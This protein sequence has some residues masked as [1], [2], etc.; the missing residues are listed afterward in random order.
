ML[1]ELSIRDIALI[2]ELRLRFGP[3]LTVLS[4][5]TGAG[6]SLVVGGLRLL[7][8]ERS[9]GEVVRTG[10][11]L[12]VVEG[13]FEIPAGGWIA[14]ELSALGIALEDGELII[15]RE[16]AASGRGRV[17]INGETVPLGTLTRAAE[18]LIDLHGQHE[19]QSLFRTA[20]QLEALDDYAG[21]AELRA[22]FA[23]RFA[24]W[25]VLGEEVGRLRAGAREEGA[26][27]EL[28][29]FQ[30]AELEA[31]K[32]RRGELD[33]L[34]AELRRLE[35]AARIRDTADR[36]V[37]RL[38]DGDGAVGDVASE[39]AEAAARAAESDPAWTETARALESLA[40]SARE[41][42][43]DVR[44]LGERAVADPERLEHVRERTRVLQ[45]LLRRW[46]PDEDALFAAWE[47]LRVEGGDPEAYERLLAEK[48]RELAAR[49]ADTAE[50][51]AR[52]SRD[53][54][55]GA[56]RLRKAMEAALA[57]LGMDGTKFEARVAPRDQ[58]V[59][60]TEG[61]AERAA[62][63]GLDA[64]EYLL[65]AN[66]GETMRALR[67]VASGGEVSRVMLALQSVLGERRGTSTM[68]FDEIDAGVGGRVAARVAERLASLGERRQVLCITHLA[69]VASRAHAHLAVRKEESGG[70]TV[71]LVEPVEGEARVREIARML[72]GSEAGA[73]VEHARE[74]LREAGIRAPADAGAAVG[75]RQRS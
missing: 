7:C 8:G 40:I 58:G 19:H 66:R 20:F 55:R 50:L 52:L 2:P 45:G 73:A 15:R 12:G 28:A 68:V 9:G 74:L 25:R 35:N 29:R 49:G 16:I 61:G 21:S 11:E 67:E 6:K 75:D 36:V 24:A 3:G 33:E 1:A 54:R 39:A 34:R 44:A 41:L 57:D 13:V 38:A 46:G 71:S 56:G 27:R 4:G 23:E 48:E 42:A 69:Q 31:A 51:G 65:A 60:L 17:R 53:R 72:G 62:A 5:E 63:T 43:R 37:E 26:R 18:C 30:L 70:R 64:V 22:E 10:S 32:P 59:A 14:G 47:R